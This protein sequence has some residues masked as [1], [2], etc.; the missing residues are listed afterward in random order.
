MKKSKFYPALV[1]GSICLVVAVL[2]SVINYFTAPIIEQREKDKA[3]GALAVV[4]PGGS[5]FKPMSTDGL[6]EGVL[7]AHSAV[8]GYVF[9]VQGNGRNGAIVV[10]VGVD[11]DGKIAGTQLISNSESAGYK[12]PV[13]A[14]V[15]GPDTAYKGQ[16]LAN[17]EAI[18][19][20]GS[21]MTSKGYAEAINVALRAFAAVSGGDSRTPEQIFQDNCNAALGTEGLTFTKWFATEVVT[22]V[23]NVYEASDKSGFVFEIGESLIGVNSTGVTT[24]GVSAE[25]SEKALAAHA[26]IAASTLTEI[27][28]IPAVD[29]SLKTSITKISKT[30]SGN[31]VFELSATGYDLG[32]EYSDGHMPGNTPSPI[33]IKLSISA[34]GKIIDVVTVSHKETAGKGDCDTEEY[35]EGWKGAESSDVT[36]TPGVPT[37]NSTHTQNATD[38]G[39][40]SGATYTTQGY[41]SAVKAAFT[42]FELL[43]AEGGN[44]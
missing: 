17:Y 27:T 12:E 35:Y 4:L 11:S 13:F 40:L 39:V 18:I 28:E 38:L 29:Q 2:L 42:A 23:D 21:T 20:T 6:P 15:D 44:D 33:L 9:K 5:D 25:D 41:Q 16:D 8:G 30:A 43:T 32:F 3:A 36:I 22:G 1:L 19:V 7:E 24:E 31:Y 10:M 34:E 37:H 14:Q 26:I